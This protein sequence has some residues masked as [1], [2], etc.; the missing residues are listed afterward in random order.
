MPRISWSRRVGLAGALLL[1]VGGAMV[2]A[3]G[4]LNGSGG[5]G[6]NSSSAPLPAPQILAPA[7]TL[8]RDVAVD[9]SLTRPSGL[10]ATAD[11]AVR[12]TVNGATERERPLPDQEQFVISGIALSEGENSIRAALV[13]DT[14][15][16]A[17]SPALT[18]TRD[19]T[20]PVIR[21]TRPEAGATVYSERFQLRGR[22]EAGATLDVIDE[23]TDTALD[24][25][26]GADGRF[27]ADLTLAVGANQLVLSSR[28]PAG[29]TT[30]THVV[31]TRADS[32]QALTLTVSDD[33]LKQVDLP[34]RL[35]ATAFIQDERGQPVD[36][37]EVTFSL[38]PPNATTITYRTLSVAGEARWPDLDIYSADDPLGAWLV[39]VL[40]ELPSGTELRANKTVNVR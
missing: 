13:D 35:V 7:Q 38:S 32:L 26:V 24:T 6:P 11:Y 23:G 37:A 22:T 29:N 36:G 12:I 10:D 14:G 30:S 19:T 40:V 21:V 1:A 5:H 31:I 34:Q 17:A 15:V 18:I 4:G 3:G 27:S 25:S 2:F 20:A 28:D 9:L 8:T 39:T 16:G 33:Q